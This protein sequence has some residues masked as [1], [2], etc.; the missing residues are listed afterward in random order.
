VTAASRNHDAFDGSLA[1]EAGLTF[2]AVD[3]VLQLEEACF[4][5]GVDI[6]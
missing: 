5:I 2:A 4:A 6:I 3:L 1:D